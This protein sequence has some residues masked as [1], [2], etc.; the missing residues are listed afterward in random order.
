[1]PG[2]HGRGG[3]G[4]ME[5]MRNVR[6][7]IL[8]S[9]RGQSTLEYALVL[10]AVLLAVIGMVALAFKPAIQQTVTDSSNAVK[11]ASGKLKGGL[12]F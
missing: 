8:R 3:E 11:S 2:R 4:L 7:V 10:G 5:P 9:R 6:G 12:G 1:M